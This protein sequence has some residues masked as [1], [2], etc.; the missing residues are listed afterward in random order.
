M[1][2]KVLFCITVYNG[3]AFVPRAILSALRID[4]Q[5]AEVSVLVL[6]DASPEPGWSQELAEFC[7]QHGANY[8]CTPRNLGIPRNVNLGLLSACEFGFDYVVI[9]NSDTIF[10]ANIVSSLLRGASQKGVGAVTAWSNNVSIYS[11]GNADPDKYLANQETVDWLSS[12]LA[13]CYPTELLDIP[14]GI[15]FCIMIPTAVVRD[16]GITDPC[17]GRGYCEETDLSLRTLQA[18][19][20][21]CLAPGSFVYH[22]GRGTN[23]S[24]GLVTAAATTVPKNEA[25]IDLRYPDFRNS[26]DRFIASQKMQTLQGE[27]TQKIIQLAGKSNGYQVTV[28]DV[29]LPEDSLNKVS[30]RVAGGTSETVQLKYRGFS[31]SVPK[32]RLAAHAFLENLFGAPASLVVVRE[33]GIQAQDLAKTFGTSEIRTV[34][35]YPALI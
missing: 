21:M 33:R 30:V 35:R 31:A 12:E 27:A 10:P 1:K 3:R 8:Y 34:C 26:V 18:G 29:D 17:F 22:Q 11:L 15:S 25:I 9:C 2:P 4:Q 5:D 6:D 28:G 20:R 14:A 16:V 7:S 13:M 23:L 19:Y 32:G 24:A